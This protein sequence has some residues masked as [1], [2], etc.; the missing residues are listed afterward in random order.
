M[1]G[2]QGVN[3]GIRKDFFNKKL[4]VRITGADI[5]RTDSNF[6]YNGNYGG[7][8]TSGVR[9]FDN[10]RFGLGATY[11]FGNQKLKNTKKNNNALDEELRRLQSNN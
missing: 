10:Q 2:N 6:Y 3:F 7:I 5:F 11:T 8:E 1:D 4:Q 9:T